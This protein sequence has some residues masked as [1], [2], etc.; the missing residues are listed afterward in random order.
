MMGLDTTRKRADA[1]DG[2]TSL[3][4]SVRETCDELLT[5]T[6]LL[7]TVMASMHL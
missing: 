5:E 4:S 2:I 6:R 7:N 3:T 1:G